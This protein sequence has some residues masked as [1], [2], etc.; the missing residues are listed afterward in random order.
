GEAWSFLPIGA[1]VVDFVLT[2]AISVSAASSA[3]IAYVPSLAGVR[4]PMALALLVGVAGLTWFGHVGR[5]VFAAMTLFFVAIGAVVVIGGLGTTGVAHH[6]GGGAS[7]APAGIAVLLAFPVAMALATGVEAPS[8]AV[9][10]LGQLDVA[11]RRRF[12]RITLWLTLGIVG[13]LTLGLAGVAVKLGIGIPPAH[14]TQI[15]RV[16]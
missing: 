11:G 13:A 15:A 5:A 8:T 14:S 10:Q 6:A 9:A 12:A 2:I 4:V 7:T 3:V 1:L 16:A